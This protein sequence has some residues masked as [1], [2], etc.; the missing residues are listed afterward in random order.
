MPRFRADWVLPVSSPPLHRHCLTVDAGRI[1]GLAHDEGEA[2]DLGSVALLPGLVNAHTHLELSY[3]RGAVGRSTR[4]IDW[5]R[6]LL[7]IRRGQDGA[8]SER[9]ASAVVAAVDEARRSGTILFG[10]VTN[11]LAIVPV[12]DAAGVSASVFLELI[13]FAADD[14]RARVAGARSSIDALGARTTDVRIGLAAHAPYSVSRALFEAIRADVERTQ[15]GRSCVH[16]AES[17]EEVE[18][19]ARGTGPWRGVLEELGAWNPEWRVPGGSPVAYLDDIGFL[20]ARVMAVHAVQCTGEDLRLLQSRG[21]TIVSCPRSNQYVGVGAP[22]LEAFYAMDVEVAFG[23]DS[24]ASVETLSLFDELAE[25]RR[26]APRVPASALLRSATYVGARALGFEDD[27]GSLDV[28]RRSE[29]LVVRVPQDV[30]DVEEY[31]VGGVD[32][33]DISWLDTGI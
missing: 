30:T 8:S 2:V 29:V 26:L 7:R 27:Y 19:V 32:A 6:E 17:P 11:S 4:F 3:L 28:G 20:D 24:L 31:L 10:D 33:A 15:D 16:L 21:V 12:L 22:P 5:V 25:A 14:G 23:T 9:I 1:V 13:G 18:F